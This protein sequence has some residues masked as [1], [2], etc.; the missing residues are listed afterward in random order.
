VLEVAG[1][2]A[3]L[4]PRDGAPRR[5]EKEQPLS[6]FQEFVRH[7][8]EGTQLRITAAEAFDISELALRCREAADTRSTIS[9][10]S[11]T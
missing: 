10:R 5:L 2:E 8:E 4:F 9:V 1:G 6:M 3:M 7:L 11:E